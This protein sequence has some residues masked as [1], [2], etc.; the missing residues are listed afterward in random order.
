MRRNDRI[1]KD[2]IAT[3]RK[4]FDSQ[5]QKVILFGSRARHDARKDSDI[6]I[7]LI[8]HD[9][10]KEIKDFIDETAATLLFEKGI[11]LSTFILTEGQYS[12]MQ[13]EPFIINAQKEGVAL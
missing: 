1:V 9:A 5:L 10:N 4:R 2:F 11:L 3:I 8:F 6:D 13:F 12:Q 7:L